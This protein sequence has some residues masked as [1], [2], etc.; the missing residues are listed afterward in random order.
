MGNFTLL[1]G[2]P[3]SNSFGLGIQAHFPTKNNGKRWTKWKRTPSL[4]AIF[5][6]HGEV[7]HWPLVL[8]MMTVNHSSLIVSASETTLLGL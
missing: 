2:L 8:G 3:I 4:S 5:L 6:Q 7:E 1:G